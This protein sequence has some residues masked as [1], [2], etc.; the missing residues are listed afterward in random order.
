[1]A[2]VGHQSFA[3]DALPRFLRPP[4]PFY[5]FNFNVWPKPEV[6]LPLYKSHDFPL[7]FPLRPPSLLYRDVFA[8]VS[9][10]M[11]IYSYFPLVSAVVKPSNQLRLIEPLGLREK[12]LLGS[13]EKVASSLA[14][15]LCELFF[16]MSSFSSLQQSN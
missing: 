4:G 1:M 6:Y 5:Y 2:D 7:T 14:N 8:S 15:D 16:Y 3:Q 10:S 12:G 9:T 11:V 13:T